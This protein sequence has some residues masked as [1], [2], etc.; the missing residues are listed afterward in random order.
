MKK[1]MQKGFTLIELMIVVAIIGI[2][3]A[4]A[5]P[6]YQNY[7][8]RSKLAEAGSIFGQNKI[9]IEEFWSQNGTLAGV[10]SAA[11]YTTTLQGTYLSG[12][13]TATN[14]DASGGDFEFINAESNGTDPDATDES[15]YF[16]ANATSAGNLS[17]TYDC[18]Q[19]DIDAARCP[20]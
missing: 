7:T 11:G 8:I 16:Q 12:D 2:L 5:L 17:W 9:I 4:I 19:G 1:Q 18:S 20:F 6:A 10:V 15:F 3:A 14:L 13:V